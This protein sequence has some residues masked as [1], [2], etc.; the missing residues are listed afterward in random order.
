VNSDPYRILALDGGGLR[1]IFTAAVLYEAEESF[2]PAFLDSFD[3]LV[4]T[5][6]GGLLAL[7]LA[8]GRTCSEMLAFYREAGPVIF[9]HPR[10]L[11]RLFRP[12][13]DRRQLD[14]VLREQFG[15]QT[16]LNDLGK[17]VCVTA[18]ELVTGTT[19]VIKDDH[20]E[21][22]RWGG[23][24]LVWKV[25]AAT[26]AAPTYFAPVQF[27]QADSHV[28]GGVWGNN[29]AMVGIIEA[30]RYGGRSLT[31]IRMLSVGTTSAALRVRS[32]KAASK[33]GLASWSTKALDL[34]QNSASLAANN[35]VRL[36]LGDGGYLRLDSETA[37]KV[38]LDDA[39]QCAPLA[40]WG[41]D[42]GRK[43]IS[44]IGELLGL[45]RA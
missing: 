33:M 4:G 43:S 42:V 39:S 8:S 19:R 25:A 21:S 28:D 16:T 2:G 27:G 34:L 24:Q 29:P 9:G 7:G 38:K 36:L 23:D 26:S 32:H 5:S 17:S 11:L 45:R 10:R 1:G 18:H 13:Y 20:H 30:V 35:Q 31:D 6:T 15:D 12:K 3:L 41:H 44:E 14:N 37:Q 40:E 22:L